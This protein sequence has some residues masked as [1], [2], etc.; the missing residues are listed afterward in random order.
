MK[1][2]LNRLLLL[3]IAVAPACTNPTIDPNATLTAAGSVVDETG[4]PLASAE[5]RLVKYWSTLNALR[6]SVETLFSE[7]P[8]GDS[9]LGVD[10]VSSVQTNG[11][12]EFE[13]VFKGRDI[14]KPGG[15]TD[16]LGNVEVADA[17]LV[18]RDP[19]DES[20]LSGVFTYN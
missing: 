16:D 1:R 5:V 13:F 3:G 7:D 4:A 2:S 17:V 6:P 11:E 18:V 8:S 15:F 20:K 9:V 12:G 14:Q 19:L 10:L